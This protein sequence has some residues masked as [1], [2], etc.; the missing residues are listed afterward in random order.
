MVGLHREA[1]AMPIFGWWWLGIV[2]AITAVIGV[3]G[4]AWWWVP[5]WQM[6]SVTTGDPKARADI[7]DN[8]RKTVGQALGGIA[9]LLGAVAAYLQFTQQQDAA[10]DLLISN[11]VAK[12]FE[13]L[14]SDKLTIRL[15]GIYALEGVMNTSPQY[16]QPVLEALCAFVRED[17]IGMVINGAPATDIQATLTV[18]RRRSSGPGRIDLAQARIAEAD[19]SSANLYGATLTHATLTGADLTGADLFRADL[20]GADLTGAN[21]TD[22]NLLVADL[23]RT[24]LTGANL[25]GADLTGATLVDTY[26]TDANLSGADLTRAYLSGDLTRA[27][28]TGANLTRAD[29]LA[30]LTGAYLPDAT[31][32]HADLTRADLTLATL[33]LA[34]LTGADLTDADLTGADLTGANLTDADLTDAN[35][36]KVVG[37]SL[38]QQLRKACGK[39]PKVLLEGFTLD[40]PCPRKH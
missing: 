24:K 27:N 6:K 36:I 22:A 5:K 1:T 9:V 14:G 38:E 30:N 31:L 2:I 37:L 3:A 17:T 40:R 8:F 26:L 20:T 32:S 18:L 10:H 15:G 34:N 25:S 11:Q 35:L 23:T 33:T 29:L 12:G 4:A 16:Y 28:L 39:K 19:L 13:Q 21:L 7:E